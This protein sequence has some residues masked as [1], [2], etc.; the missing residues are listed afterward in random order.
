MI[1][2]N[3][4]VPGFRIYG[5]FRN[6]QVAS[7]ISSP[8]VKNIVGIWYVLESD[9]PDGG[10]LHIW[11][12]PGFIPLRNC[13]GPDEYSPS[14]KH[15]QFTGP[16]RFP[17][18]KTFTGLPSGTNCERQFDAKSGN[19]YIRIDP[20]GVLEY[21]I[22]YAF[23]FGIMNAMEVNYAKNSWRFETNMTGVILHLRRDVEGF[24]LQE[25]KFVDVVPFDTTSLMPLSRADISLM[26]EKVIPGLSKISISAPKGFLPQCALFRTTGLAATTTCLDN[27]N[28]ITF[29]VDTQD[30]KEPNTLITFHIRISN[31]EF[32]PQ[33]NAW[34]FSIV[35]GFGMFVDIRE[36]FA[37]YDITGRLEADVKSSFAYKAQRNRI[38]LVFVPSTILNQADEENILLLEAPKG[39][40]F[41]FVPGCS[42]FEFRR[43][44]PIASNSQFFIGSAAQQVFPPEETECVGFDNETMIVRFPQ[45]FGMLRD[46][47]TI[48]VDVFN[49][50]E[51][52]LDNTWLFETRK[53]TT[54][55][56]RYV[57]VDANRSLP[58]FEIDSLEA[59]ITEQS[60]AHGLMGTRFVLFG[61]CGGMLLL[62]CVYVVSILLVVALGGKEWSYV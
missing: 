20:V 43:T 36:S 31:P 58:G 8:T 18:D 19:W 17:E 4:D 45:G 35:D 50:A 41:P 39:Y 48:M 2:C 44:N 28:V 6:A 59:L 52:P 40:V 9:L 26:T 54:E 23:Q 30:P 16:S 11:M 42:R 14:Y 32:T 34:A 7:A 53:F 47:Y 51:E 55:D 12:P 33:P 29:T 57:I 27:K 46:N 10:L 38:T 61:S 62:S 60:A 3:Y 1:D 13:G 37:G 56:Q 25:L 24:D 22:N 21:G 5:E 15:A 49:P